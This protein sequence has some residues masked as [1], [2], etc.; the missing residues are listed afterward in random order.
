MTKVRGA[1]EADSVRKQED[2]PK[3]EAA[4]AVAA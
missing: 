2:R 1:V 3:M 4:A